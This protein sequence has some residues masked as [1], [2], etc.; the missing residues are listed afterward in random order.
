M[1]FTELELKG[2]Y[3]IDL[4]KREDSRGFFARYFCEE[5]FNRQGLASNWVQI[6][7]SMSMRPGTL[8]GLHFQTP[9]HAEV[10]LVRCLRGAIWDVI[11]DLRKGSETYGKWFGSEL[12]ETNR[13]MMYVPQGF[14]HGFVSIEKN[15]EILY[16]VSDR[17]HP[18]AEKTLLW[19]DSNVSIKWPRTPTLISEKDSAGSL[20]RDLLP[21]EI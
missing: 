19:S 16:L 18:E 3:L 9:P 6:N 5:E 21:L 10:K 2:A 11:V 8:R 15:S 1:K 14:A 7:N 12:N 20:L 4:E 17:Y 13:S